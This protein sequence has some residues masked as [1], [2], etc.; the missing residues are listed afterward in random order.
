M[1]IVEGKIEYVENFVDLVIMTGER[2]L[3]STFGKNLRKMLQVLYRS[4][5]NLFSHECAIF[6]IE[7]NA[8]L[9]MAH[10]YS[11]DYAKRWRLRTGRLIVKQLGLLK[12]ASL[13]KIDRVLGKHSPSEFYLSNLAV[14]P[15]HR[16][17]GVGKKLLETIFMIAR[18]KFCNRVVLDVEEDNKTAKIFYHRM[19]FEEITENTVKV[20]GR[21]FHFIRMSCKLL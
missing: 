11:Y 18:A 7:Q 9:G 5:S 2:F 13:L 3:F 1:E 10:G 17:M 4:S 12:V 14:Y 16:K 19:G 21:P 8:V 15:Q 20:G 6:A